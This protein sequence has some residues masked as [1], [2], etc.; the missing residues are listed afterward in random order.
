MLATIS[1][2]L[3]S[4]YKVFLNRSCYKTEARFVQKINSD[5]SFKVGAGVRI[6][7]DGHMLPVEIEHCHRCHVIREKT[8]AQQVIMNKLSNKTLK[9]IRFVILNPFYP[10]INILN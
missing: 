4:S 6:M 7:E 10:N 1:E 9:F 3:P 8:Y 2:V 5:P